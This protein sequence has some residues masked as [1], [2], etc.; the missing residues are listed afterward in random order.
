MLEALQ[1]TLLRNYR[2]PHEPTLTSGLKTKHLQPATG[3]WLNNVSGRPIFI[4]LFCCRQHLKHAAECLSTCCGI[5]HKVCNSEN[6]CFYYKSFGCFIKLL[7]VST[8]KVHH[9]V[10]ICKY[11]CWRSAVLIFMTRMSLVQI[12]HYNCID[13]F[14]G[15]KT[16][17]GCI[18]TAR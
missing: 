1:I 14:P 11:L 2:K 15:L 8:P 12:N 7:H 18:F 17:Y 3:T 4:Q 16:H 10:Q 5:K 9:Q 6:N 13:W